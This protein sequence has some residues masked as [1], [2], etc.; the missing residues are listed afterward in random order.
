MTAPAA[1]MER[2]SSCGIQ[3]RRDGADLIATPREALTDELRGLIRD[4]KRALLDALAGE[5]ETLQRDPGAAEDPSSLT[6]IECSGCDRLEMREETHLGTRRRFWWRC[7][8]GHELLEAR[9]YGERV[10][11]APPE[12]EAAGDFRP[13]QAGTK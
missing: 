1:V 12:C 7:T 6:G 5:T 4:H 2:L 11:I 13:W 8:Q 10:T 9:R 3:L